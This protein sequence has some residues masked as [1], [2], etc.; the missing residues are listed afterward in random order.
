MNDSVF[1]S[2]YSHIQCHSMLVCMSKGE[3]ANTCL[4]PDLILCLLQ[5]N[6]HCHGPGISK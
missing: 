6:Y 1:L 4:H 3:Q 5:L 2:G